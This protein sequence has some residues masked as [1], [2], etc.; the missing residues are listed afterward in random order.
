MDDLI[1]AS[2]SP[3]RQRL[4]RWLGLP[5]STAAS[6]VEDDPGLAR[7]QDPKN[8]AEQLAV[9]KASHV[10]ATVSGRG[11]LVLGFDTLVVIDGQTLGKPR[12]TDEA[13]EM[14]ARLAGRAHEV[15]TGVAAIRELDGRTES[16]THS[17]PVLMRSLSDEDTGAWLMGDEVLGCAGAYNIERHLGEVALDQCFQNVAGLPLCHSYLLLRTAYGLA[18][19]RPD[20]P[21]NA[22][23][24]VRCR[25]APR[26]LDN[27][28]L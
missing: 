15:I 5:F 26:L 23:R 28:G 17:T 8:L 14:L 2:A 18:P 24:Q 6:D 9:A 22:A 7:A 1:L 25:L 10:A 11:A 16:F 13:R 3:R 12:G 4:A 21:C 20:G 19:I 27:D